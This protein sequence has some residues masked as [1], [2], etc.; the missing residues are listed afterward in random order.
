MYDFS[1]PMA[2]VDY[3]PVFFFGTAAVILLRDLYCK[4][5]KGAY[6]LL[7][8]GTI[9]IFTAGFLKATW[10]LLYA[11]GICDF[12][13]LNSIFLPLQS[14]GFLLA[15]IGLIGVFFKKGKKSAVLAVTPPVFSGSMV[16]IMMMVAGLGAICTCLSVLA[17][18]MK[19]G[20][21]MVFFIIA[22]V[23]SMG[24]GYM[25]SHDSTSAAVNWIEQGINCVGQGMLMTGVLILHRNGLKDAEFTK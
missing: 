24:M 8:A 20:W 2:L 14:L 18:K 22:F 17:A 9:N 13:A 23:A 4:M 11:A 5:V 7:A 21:V 25:S 1:V 19:K 3:I 12:Q 15:G 16:F 6:A 10:K